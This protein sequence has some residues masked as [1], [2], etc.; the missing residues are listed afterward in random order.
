MSGLMLSLAQMVQDARRE[1]WV[2]VEGR[3]DSVPYQASLLGWEVIPSRK[4]GPER[5]VLKP[6]K[7]QDAPKQ[8]LS[9][10][11][12]YGAQPLHTDGSHHKE[13]P[14]IVLL[15]VEAPSKVPTM[16]WQFP[17]LGIP[18]ETWHDLRH[19]LFTVRTG[20]SAFLAPAFNRGRVRFD[21]GCM[22]PAD[23]RSGRVIDFFSRMQSEAFRHEWT[24]SGLILAIDNR[25]VLHARGPAEEEPDR[26]MHRIAIR[27]PEENK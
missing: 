26:T 7:S 15:S 21:P 22:T 16:L 23:S 13:P 24:A 9:A 25:K 27:V 2:S 3:F 20:S 4:S 12:G 6:T 1:G 17:D 19:G 5:D 8:S 11:Y 18:A 14:D 10:K